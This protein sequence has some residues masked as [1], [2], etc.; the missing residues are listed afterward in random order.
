MKLLFLMTQ[1]TDSP[2]GLGRY[3]P[4]A[5]ALV[6]Q[7]WTV[8]IVA[9]HPAFDTLSTRQFIEEGVHVTYVSQMHVRKDGS[10]KSYYGPVQLLWISLLAIWRLTVATWRSDADFI[11]LC[12]PQPFN[13][14]AARLARRGRP[15][16]CDCDDYEAETN[17]FGRAWQKRLVQYFEDAIVEF[18][19]GL[20]VN[21]RFTENRYVKLGFPAARIR[22]VPNGVDNGRFAQTDQ[23]LPAALN[24]VD[25]S[26]PLIGYVGT[27]GLTSHP[28]DLL[29][30]AFAKVAATHPTAQLLLVGGGEDYGRL[31]QMAVEEGIA[32]RTIFAGRLSPALVPTLLQRLTVSVDPVHDDL[33]ARARSPLKVVESLAVGTPVVTSDVGDRAQMLENGRL[34]TLVTAG[35]E[36]ALAKGLLDLLNQPEAVAGMRAAIEARAGSWSWD[37][38]VEQFLPIY[39]LGGK[40]G[41]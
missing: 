34:G 2:S 13:V 11:Q 36:L 35:D 10:Q 26:Q 12:K 15:I 37:R 3:L 18:A 25:F 6:R 30:K 40:E 21:T 32:D 20:T 9:L 27:L 33:V 19:A 38:L 8:D 1:S 24:L 22:Y 16:F 41:V 23:P 7:G 4:L 39:Q 28:V 31:Q 5:K 29:L 17:R 14:L